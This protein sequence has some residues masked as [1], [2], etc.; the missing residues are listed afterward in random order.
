MGTS[1][2]ECLTGLNSDRCLSLWENDN[3]LVDALEVAKDIIVP[4]DVLNTLWPCPSKC[5]LVYLISTRDEAGYSVAKQVRRVA[6]ASDR[7]VPLYEY[8]PPSSAQLLV[9]AAYP[10]RVSQ[11]IIPDTLRFYPLCCVYVFC[12]LLVR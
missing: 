2:N 12:S 8:Q 10:R 6:E 11:V 4:L 7:C 5:L 3:T 9:T 1:A